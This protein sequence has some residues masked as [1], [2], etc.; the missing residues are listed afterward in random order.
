MDSDSSSNSSEPS[1][2]SAYSGSGSSAALDSQIS[3][4]DWECISYNPKLLTTVWLFLDHKSRLELRCASSELKED[5][6]DS[7]SHELA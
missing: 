6:E 3:I 7:V 2:A 1:F 5:I 4:G